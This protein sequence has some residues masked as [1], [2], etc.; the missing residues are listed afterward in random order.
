MQIF[1]KTLT[2]KTITLE[3]ESSDTIG[4]FKLDVNALQPKNAREQ[5]RFEIQK[6]IHYINC[7]LQR[8]S[9]PRFRIRKVS[10]RTSSVSFS[11]ASSSKMVAPSLTTTSRRSLLSIWSSVSVVESLSLLSRFLPAN[12]T[13]IR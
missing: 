13:R 11:P 9:R 6:L 4:K 3:V 5:T 10:P 1:V 8:M 2:G 7:N 12:I